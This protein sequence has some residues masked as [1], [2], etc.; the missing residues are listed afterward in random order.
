MTSQFITLETK[1]SKLVIAPNLGGSIVSFDFVDIPVFYASS[2]QSHHLTVH[3][4]ACFPLIPFSNRIAHGQFNWLNN[5][6]HI[7]PNTN[8]IAHPIHG[9]G[10]LSKW[11]LLQNEHM[12]SDSDS[13]KLGLVYEAIDPTIW[14]FSF[15]AIQS[16][17][18]TPK[19]LIITLNLKN[20]G[21]TTIPAG[22]GWHPYFHRT[23][24][25]ECITHVSAIWHNDESM[26][27]SSKE[28]LTQIQIDSYFRPLG[29]P[30]QPMLDNCF[31]WPESQLSIIQPEL[32][33]QI[34][35]KTSDNMRYL[36][37]YTPSCGEKFAL[38]PVTHRNAA[39]NMPN[40]DE[41]GIYALK[42]NQCL[43]IM[44][45]IQIEPLNP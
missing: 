34:H 41:F 18:L 14:P 37:V 15:S 35:L 13:V 25:S 17:T 12:Q 36:T 20:T 19:G 23:P 21:H 8:F 16:F 6:Y 3:Q 1:Q 44:L 24:L 38:E 31:D 28:K 42:P 29:I 22:L 5:Q 2:Y 32:N 30:P 26:L 7:K 33:R 10:W 11:H 43:E 40:P 4:M 45:D 27:P 39:I 9:L